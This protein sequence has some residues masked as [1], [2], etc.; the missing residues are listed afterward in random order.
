MGELPNAGTV[1]AVML[2][3]AFVWNLLGNLVLP[4]SW[5]IPANLAV[6]ALL[7]ML[8]R[9]AGLGWDQLGMSTDQIRRGV[10]IGPFAAVGGA[11]KDK[12]EGSGLEVIAPVF[13]RGDFE[14]LEAMGISDPKVAQMVA[15]IRKTEA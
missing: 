14:R 10:G 3:V 13:E 4:Y 9:S 2:L 15:L 11:L 7:V 5:Y 8:A 1:L 6:A 12:Y